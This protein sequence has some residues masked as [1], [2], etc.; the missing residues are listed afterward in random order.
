MA[1]IF[2]Q[3][4][5]ITPHEYIMRLKI[6]KASTLLLTSGLS[7]NEIGYFLG[8]NDSYHFASVFK[9]FR[10]FDKIIFISQVSC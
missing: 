2:R 7:I 5:R 10:G 3:Y 9:R 4:G 8:F 1:R 6:N